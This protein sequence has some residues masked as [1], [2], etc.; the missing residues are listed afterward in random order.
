[1]PVSVAVL[2]WEALA[3]VASPLSSAAAIAAGATNKICTNA[4]DHATLN[5]LCFEVK[6]TLP[7]VPLLTD[8]SQIGANLRVYADEKNRADFDQRG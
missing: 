5:Y 1:M 2:V 7:S 4:T 3:P 8:D 6:L